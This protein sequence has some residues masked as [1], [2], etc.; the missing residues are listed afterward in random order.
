MANRFPNRSLWTYTQTNSGSTSSEPPQA[1]TPRTP[2]PH[3]TSP[4]GGRLDP[5]K[6]FAPAQYF[7]LGAMDCDPKGDTFRTNWYTKHLKALDEPSLWA[8]SRSDSRATVYRFLW[9]RSFHH[10]VSVRLIIEHDRSGKLVTK[11]TGGAGGYEP[12]SLILNE[13]KPV[14]KQLTTHFLSQIVGTHFWELETD[15]QPGGLDGS[16][17][18]LEG[19]SD[20]HYQII[21]RWSP[22]PKDPLR[23]LAVTLMSDFAGIKIEPAEVY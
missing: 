12:G 6:A 21:D 23:T 13:S 18:I 2:E 3:E 10:P 5:E 9:L 15:R 7:P 22:G 17:W 14:G 11:I 19:V 8:L 1:L 20:G 4:C 16:Q